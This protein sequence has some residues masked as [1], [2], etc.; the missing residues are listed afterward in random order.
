MHDQLRKVA[1]KVRASIIEIYKRGIPIF[2]DRNNHVYWNGDDNLYPNEIEGI[3]VNSATASRAAKVM[4]KYIAGRG[5]TDEAQDV[6]VNKKKNYRLSNMATFIAGNMA[7]QGGCFIHVGYGIAD[8]GTIRPKQLDVLDYTKCRIN[9][10]DDAENDGKIFYKDYCDQRKGYLWRGSKKEKEKWYYPFNPI[11]DVVRAQIA[12]DYKDDIVTPEDFV[13]A[14]EHYRGQV[15][16]LNLTPEYK[17]AL[18]PVDSVYN[19][20]DTEYRI[21]LYTN[22]QV[23]S[24]FLGKTAVITQ[25]LDDEQAEEIKKDIAEWLGAEN[26]D[27][28]FHMDVASAD[29]LDNVLKVIQLKGQYDEK[30]FTETNTRIRKHILGAFNNIPEP[31]LFASEGAL[32]GTSADT[33]TEMKLFYSEQTE[34]ER[35]RLQETLIFLGFECEI[36]PIVKPIT[37][38]TDA[39]A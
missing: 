18:A 38:T 19:D 25:G 15:F 2:Q 34:E 33:Y 4:A 20:A 5:F 16:Y 39:T 29:N 24:G 1:K 6:I 23:R 37:T 7:K 17:Y 8:D 31:L 10:E 21:S 14:L 13:T 3:V 35:Y 30:M 28:V 11:Q 12:R 9:K 27:N 36:E 26:T 22:M 32:F